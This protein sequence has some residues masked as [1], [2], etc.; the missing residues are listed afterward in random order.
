MLFHSKTLHILS[1]ELKDQKMRAERKTTYITIINFGNIYN[2]GLKLSWYS[3]QLR[4][5]K[6]VNV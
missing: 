6:D 5:K 4:V 3:G 1:V 2:V